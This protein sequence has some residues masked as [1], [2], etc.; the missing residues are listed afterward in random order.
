MTDVQ[1][2]T[3][4]VDGGVLPR[5]A[6]GAA[7]L[8][9]TLLAVTQ[10]GIFLTFDRSDI[11][12]SSAGPAFRTFSI[13]HALAFALLVLALVALHVRTA[14]RGGWGRFV[15]FA[16]AALGTMALGADMWFEAFTSP[17][18]MEVVPQLLTVPKTA[19]WQAGFLSSFILFAVGWVAFGISCLRTKEL[20]AA[21][22][23]AVVVGGVVGFW[24][25]QPPFALPLALALVAAGVWIRRTDRVPAQG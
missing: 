6:G 8:A 12:A 14:H 1:P 19:I 24:A 3:R 21:I 11:V 22:S 9:G 25:A 18:L 4:P 10:V 15:A 16:A 7:I 13:G 23:V 17:W 20:P 2:A 5:I